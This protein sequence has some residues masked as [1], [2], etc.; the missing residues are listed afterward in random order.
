MTGRGAVQSAVA[1]SAATV[2][3]AGYLNWSRLEAPWRFSLIFAGAGL[4]ASHISL[5][6]RP[7][8]TM[9]M[10][11]IALALCVPVGF[12]FIVLLMYLFLA[13]ANLV[14]LA[15]QRDVRR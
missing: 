6:R 4:V 2:V 3:L 5:L 10:M 8:A 7:R 9:Q 1:V 15:S 14:L 12:S 13:I 11:A